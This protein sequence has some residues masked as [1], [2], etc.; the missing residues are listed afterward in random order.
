MSKS[1]EE[2]IRVVRDPKSTLFE[3]VEAVDFLVQAN[4]TQPEHLLECLN[5]RGLCAETAAIRLHALTHRPHANGFILD[6]DDW[7]NYLRNT[8]V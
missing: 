7:A 2:A 8:G 6:H 4:E 1:I 3:C 5:R